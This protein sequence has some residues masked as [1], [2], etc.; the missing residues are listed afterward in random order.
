MY[1]KIGPWHLARVAPSRWSVLCTCSNLGYSH[2]HRSNLT[3]FPLKNNFSGGVKKSYCTLFKHFLKVCAFSGLFFSF[4]CHQF[5]NVIQYYLQTICPLVMLP[6]PHRQWF[7]QLW[8]S[9]IS[10]ACIAHSTREHRSRE[11]VVG[12][13]FWTLFKRLSWTNHSNKSCWKMVIAIILIFSI[14]SLPILATVGGFKPLTC[15]FDQ[16]LIAHLNAQCTL[17]FYCK[18][19]LS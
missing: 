6:Y 9:P 13:H 10:R 7:P 5:Y 4:I 11:S 19:V 17:S 3:F 8:N 12:M 18:S 15:L 16:M 2:L 14:F 1:R